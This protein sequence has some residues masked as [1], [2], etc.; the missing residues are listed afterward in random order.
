VAG[1]VRDA[2]G[3]PVNVLGFRRDTILT[4][5]AVDTLSAGSV[6][7]TM[8]FKRKGAKLYGI[9]RLKL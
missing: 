6:D 1:D 3:N 4:D 5:A 8:P 7:Y 9:P 2:D